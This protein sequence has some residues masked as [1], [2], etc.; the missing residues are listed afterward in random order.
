MRNTKFIID[1][2]QPGIWTE[3]NTLNFANFLCRRKKKDN[4]SVQY[5]I[6]NIFLFATEH[7][8]FI[9]TSRWTEITEMKTPT[10]ICI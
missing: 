10:F 4:G 9:T 8:N 5:S 1:L 6:H 7:L 2:L 3:T